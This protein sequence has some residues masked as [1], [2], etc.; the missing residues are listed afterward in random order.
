MGLTVFGPLSVSWPGAKVHPWNPYHVPTPDELQTG[1]P[2]RRVFQRF[3]RIVMTLRSHSKGALARY[4][5]KVEHA[6]TLQ[7]PLGEKL[8]AKMLADGIMRHSGKFYY[9]QPEQASK[10][11]ATSW[12]DLRRGA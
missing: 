3:R 1:R 2:L 11:V 8:L 10:H 12:Q 6:R 7:G 4:K 9:W 5:D